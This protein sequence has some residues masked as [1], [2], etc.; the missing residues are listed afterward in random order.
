MNQRQRLVKESLKPAFF[1]CHLLHL[2]QVASGTESTPRSRQHYGARAAFQSFIHGA[3]KLVPHRH[4]QRIE[5]QRAIERDDGDLAAHL[6]LDSF[7]THEF[8]SL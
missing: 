4:R 6:Q 8:I 3:T 5:R 1:V 2:A 7:V